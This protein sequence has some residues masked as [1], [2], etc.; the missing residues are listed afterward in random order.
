MSM[1]LSRSMASRAVSLAG[2][3]GAFDMQALSWLPQAGLKPYGGS[4][5]D[6]DAMREAETINGLYKSEVVHRKAPWKSMDAVAYAPLI[7]V[8][9]FN[10]RWLP[11]EAV[12]NAYARLR[13]IAIA[14]WS[15]QNCLRSYRGGSVPRNVSRWT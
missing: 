8:D 10:S 9:G 7:W 3:S 4:A 6:S 14:G 1:S 13:E 5:G 2:G 15:Q 11:A 12:A